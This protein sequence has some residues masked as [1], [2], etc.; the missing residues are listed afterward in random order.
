MKTE[1]IDSKIEIHKINNNA[2][3]YAILIDSYINKDKKKLDILLNNSEFSKHILSAN[4]K[5]FDLFLLENLEN[6]NILFDNFKK[7]HNIKDD[8]ITEDKFLN[9]VKNNNVKYSKSNKTYEVNL[10][11]N[12]LPEFQNFLNPIKKEKHN[13]SKANEDNDNFNFFEDPKIERNSKEILKF[14]E[15]ESQERIF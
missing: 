15:E 10:G 6:L 12:T 13:T 5:Q 7:E 1:N 11:L 9:Q 8:D 2:I 3:F 4:N 14:Y